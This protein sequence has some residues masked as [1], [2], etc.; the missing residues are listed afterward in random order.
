MSSRKVGRLAVLAALSSGLVLPSCSALVRILED[1]RD[2]L[3]DIPG[4]YIT[5]DDD[6]VYIELPGI[7]ITADDP[8]DFSVDFD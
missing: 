4:L 3:V 5:E 1:S 8:F 2:V 6:N 7:D